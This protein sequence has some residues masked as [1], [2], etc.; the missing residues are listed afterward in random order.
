M[1]GENEPANKYCK[2][3]RDT[4][5]GLDNIFLICIHGLRVGFAGQEEESLWY[6]FIWIIKL[7]KART[8]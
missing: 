4:A 7:T 6:P 2:R 1:I 8:F 5:S 3:V